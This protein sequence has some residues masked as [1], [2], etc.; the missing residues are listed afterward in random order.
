MKFVVLRSLLVLIN[1]CKKTTFEFIEIGL[2]NQPYKG[3]DEDDY[4]IL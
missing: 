1:G 4:V 3:H 2:N